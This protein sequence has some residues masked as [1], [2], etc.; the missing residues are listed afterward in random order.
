[1]TPEAIMVFSLKSFFLKLFGF[2]FEVQALA[3]SLFNKRS[4]KGFLE[5]SVQEGNG[6][7]FYVSK[8]LGELVGN[9]DT[10]G[11]VV[12]A[13]VVGD[14]KV[15]ITVLGLEGDGSCSMGE[16]HEFSGSL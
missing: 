9:V 6:L 2:G 8:F 15:G 16:V 3:V 1:M 10:D 14:L 7:G 4:K 5:V 11:V 13:L 12:E